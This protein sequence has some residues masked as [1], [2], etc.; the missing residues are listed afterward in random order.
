[1]NQIQNLKRFSGFKPVAIVK[2]SYLKTDQVS[3]LNCSLWS[4][5]HYTDIPRSQIPTAVPQ[6]PQVLEAF[7]DE[8]HGQQAGA[9]AVHHS[10]VDSAH[11][12]PESLLKTPWEVRQ[13]GA[14]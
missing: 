7:A 12:H 9:Q 6:P 4:S 11:L 14:G 10:A 2:T 3:A 13:A 8:F 1:M 5:T